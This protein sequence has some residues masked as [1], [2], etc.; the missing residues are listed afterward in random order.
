MKVLGT[1]IDIVETER[2]QHTFNR[3][4]KK[5]AEKIL[6]EVELN[7]LEQTSDPI[8][9]LAKRFAVKEAFVKALGT[10]ISNQVNWHCMY[11]V[12]DGLGRPSVAFTESFAREIHAD[13]LDI[14]VSI[15]D[16]KNYAIAHA[17]IFQKEN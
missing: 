8:K 4:E 12:H 13:N 6:H 3:Y 11:I 17:I 15:S 1:G 10:G 14:H 16:E 9:F 2:I 5:F 7:E